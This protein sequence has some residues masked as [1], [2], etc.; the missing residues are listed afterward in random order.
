MTREQI[1]TNLRQFVKWFSVDGRV[2]FV[3]NAYC[4]IV[5]ADAMFYKA[6]EP[7]LT[8]R[9]EE[10][11]AEYDVD[12]WKMSG[13]EFDEDAY[14]FRVTMKDGDTYDFEVYELERVDFPE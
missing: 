2:L 11:G 4:E 7:R 12:V 13:A 9:H 1:Q 3:N 14:C 5:D 8:Y 10:S 6:A